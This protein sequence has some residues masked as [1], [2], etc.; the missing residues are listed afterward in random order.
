MGAGG[1]IRWHQAGVALTKC[2]NSRP[3]GAIY[4]QSETLEVHVERAQF[5][6]MEMRMKRLFLATA[7]SAALAASASAVLAQSAS[8]PEN[9]LVAAAT[10][11]ATGTAAQPR[12]FRSAS[13]RVEARIAR[14]QQALQITSAQQAQFDTFAN[15]L[16]KQ[17]R[18]FDERIQQRRAQMQ[19]GAA[20]GMNVSAIDRMQR[21]TAERYNQLGEVIAAAKP[22]Y[23]SLSPEQ[24]QAA[25]Q[26]LA[27]R[28]GRGG[29][30]G[31][32]RPA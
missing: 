13:E 7:V 8:Q 19:Q 1:E 18:T 28:G 29:P 25:D 23:D 10:T 22:L 17:A 16:R 2:Y 31:H 5:S 3:N 9:L 14:I 32:H 27:R 20:P 12:Q 24:K 11:D 6:T 4:C 21:M 15:V 26:L 30:H